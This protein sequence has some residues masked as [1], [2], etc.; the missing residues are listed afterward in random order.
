MHCAA[1]LRSLYVSLSPTDE[2]LEASRS[3][4]HQVSRSSRRYTCIHHLS[5]IAPLVFVTDV[6]V[7]IPQER[8]R[9]DIATGASAKKESIHGKCAKSIVLAATKKRNAAVSMA[10]AFRLSGL[11]AIY[12]RLFQPGVT[13]S[14]AEFRD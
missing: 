2:L 4:L 6:V 8:Y 13:F 14:F 12:G 7:D 9:I 5:I 10:V 1:F 11:Q 3:I